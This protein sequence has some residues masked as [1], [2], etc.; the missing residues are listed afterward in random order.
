MWQIKKHHPAG[1][2]R[3]CRPLQCLP[4]RGDLYGRPVVLLE[5]PWFL[6][7]KKP[8]G[9]DRKGRPYAVKNGRYFCFYG[10]KMEVSA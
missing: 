3:E 10:Y 9:D 8:E 6:N 2:G 5:Q 7:C 1:D 4:R